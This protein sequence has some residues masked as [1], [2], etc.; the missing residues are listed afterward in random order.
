MFTTSFLKGKWRKAPESDARSS[1]AVEGGGA[2]L[3]G[4]P[5]NH[6]PA[7]AFSL[8]EGYERQW[9]RLTA[10]W[11]VTGAVSRSKHCFPAPS[12]A[13]IGYATEGALFIAA[14][15]WLEKGCHKPVL[16]VWGGVWGNCER[17]SH[18][19]TRFEQHLRDAHTTHVTVKSGTFC[20]ISLPGPE[21]EVVLSRISLCIETALCMCCMLTILYLTIRV[22]HQSHG[23]VPVLYLVTATS[24]VFCVFSLR[25]LFSE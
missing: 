12:S 2:G 1:Q 13:K 3:T 5:T 15:Q 25:Q 9:V 6:G 11:M 21:E 8:A 20:R 22:R 18:G 14:Q 16:G 4:Q 23:F 19:Q 24:T 17:D 10:W 7:V